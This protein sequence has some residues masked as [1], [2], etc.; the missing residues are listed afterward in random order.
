MPR[1][2]LPLQTEGKVLREALQL[3]QVPPHVPQE[4]LGL[5]PHVVLDAHGEQPRRPDRHPR[6]LPVPEPEAPQE[7]DLG[8]EGALDAGDEQEGGLAG[9]GAAAHEAEAPEE[10]EGGAEL[11]VDAADQDAGAAE[12]GLLEV[13]E[14]DEG[15]VEEEVEDGVEVGVRVRGEELGEHVEDAA[16]GGAGDAEGGEAGLDGAEGGERG[17]AE[18]RVVAEGLPGVDVEALQVEELLPEEKAGVRGGS[19][20]GSGG[21]GGW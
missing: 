17:G 5:G 11:G 9:D 3:G 19:G 13:G 6:D 1:P 12:D 4:I 2:D 7:L 20:S 21:G 18:V 14:G 8:Q 15:L 10:G 16:E